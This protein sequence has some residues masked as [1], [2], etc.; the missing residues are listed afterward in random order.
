MFQTLVVTP[1]SASGKN[2]RQVRWQLV[3]IARGDGDDLDVWSILDFGN[4]TG[5]FLRDHLEP[6]FAP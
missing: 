5:P 1:G 4:E 2:V 6:I 3:P